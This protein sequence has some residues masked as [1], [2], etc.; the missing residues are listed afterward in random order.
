MLVALD[1]MSLFWMAVITVMASAQK[2]PAASL[3]ALGPR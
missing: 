3:P 1:V 2:L